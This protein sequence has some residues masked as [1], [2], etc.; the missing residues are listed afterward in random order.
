MIMITLI[1]ICII[2]CSKCQK[3]IPQGWGC[4]LKT[5]KRE[6]GKGQIMKGFA[7]P[8]RAMRIISEFYNE[9]F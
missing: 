1:A 3:Q 6:L 8:E 2:I 9:E 5:E 4:V 7:E